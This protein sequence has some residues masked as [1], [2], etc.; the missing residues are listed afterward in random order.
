[1]AIDSVE[2][3]DYEVTLESSQCINNQQKLVYKVLQK[4]FGDPHQGRE[5]SNLAIELCNPD[6][7][8]LK[9]S[10]NNIEQNLVGNTID[11]EVNDN[12]PVSSG[13]CLGGLVARQIKWESLDDDQVAPT[14]DGEFNFILDGCFGPLIPV[15]IAIKG[16]NN[17]FPDDGSK[18]ILG[19]PCTSLKFRGL[20]IDDIEED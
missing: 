2:L 20:V 3:G 10:K 17:C 19:P 14:A 12:P 15:K 8:V 16:G 13:N 6:H 1:M 7:V 4:V 18:T 11:V 9:V 5:I